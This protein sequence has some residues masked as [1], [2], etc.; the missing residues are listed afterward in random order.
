MKKKSLFNLTFPNVLFALMWLPTTASAQ[1]ILVTENGDAIKAWQVDMGG[2]KIYYRD[3]EGENA[4]LKSIDKS[5]VLVW[6]KADGSRV[7]VDKNG[8]STATATPVQ[9]ASEPQVMNDENSRRANDE[10]VKR[11]KDINVQY[12]GESS[13]KDANILYCQCALLPNSTIADSKV[14]MVFHSSVSQYNGAEKLI[15]VDNVLQVIIK[16]KSEVVGG[17]YFVFGN[18]VHSGSKLIIAPMGFQIPRNELSNG[19]YTTDGVTFNDVYELNSDS[20]NRIRT[21]SAKAEFKKM[22]KFILPYI[23]FICTQ[24]SDKEQTVVNKGIYKP[25]KGTPTGSYRE[26]KQEVY[27][28]KAGLNIRNFRNGVHVKSDSGVGSKKSPHV[29]RSHYHRYWVGSGKDRHLEVRKQPETRVHAELFDDI[30]PSL[31]NIKAKYN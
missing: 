6:K 17:L 14:E 29:R 2:S 23:V 11:I 5:S 12:I 18:T 28:E 15:P 1:D 27:G 22:L 20:S 3:G 13:K 21:S 10:A 16:N 25:Y 4:A 7:V 24:N 8:E 30:L 31:V 9:Q 26:V 19:N